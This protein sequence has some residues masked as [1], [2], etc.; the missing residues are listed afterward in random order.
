MI[1]DEVEIGT[2]NDKVI[3]T[4]DASTGGFKA[5]TLNKS[6][7]AKGGAKLD[8]SNNDTGHLSEGTNLYHTT[9]NLVNLS[10]LLIQVAMVHYHIIIQL[11]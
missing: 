11:E 5:Q 8:L 6:S 4:K 1:V 7:S 3:L 9:G 2:G 10:L